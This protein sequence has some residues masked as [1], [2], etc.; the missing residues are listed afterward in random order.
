ML[1]DVVGTR[2]EIQY[3]AVRVHVPGKYYVS[4]FE[5][6]TRYF[7]TNSNTSNSAIP[8]ASCWLCLLLLLAF[9]A[10]YGS[11]YSIVLLRLGP[12]LHTYN[13]DS[14][15]V[16]VLAVGTTRAACAAAAAAAAACY[17]ARCYCLYTA[18]CT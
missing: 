18:C 5:V 3:T 10:I 16:L 1:L 7:A 6:H 4:Y 15:V 14:C 13:S 9:Y 2:V 12:K 11:I 8:V 17:T